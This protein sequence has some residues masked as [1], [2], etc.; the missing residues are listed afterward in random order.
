MKIHISCQSD[1][2]LFKD[3][4]LEDVTELCVNIQVT[5]APTDHSS[6]AFRMFSDYNGSHTKMSKILLNGNNIC[7]V[8]LI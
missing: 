5:T 2:N 6:H 8:R 1:A 7:M 4:V 3:M